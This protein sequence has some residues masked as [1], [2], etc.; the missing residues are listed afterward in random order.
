[1]PALQDI[2][3]GRVDMMFAVMG[4]AVPFVKD[5]KLKVTSTPNQDNPLMDGS[6]TPLLGCD[7]WEHAYYIDVQNE[8]PK[9]LKQLIENL[10][11]WKAASARYEALG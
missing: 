7:V 10:I 2:V 5:G 4:G 9:Y 3:T 11:D 6:G 1:M 8:G